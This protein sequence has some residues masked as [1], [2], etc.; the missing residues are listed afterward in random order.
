[1]KISTLS[2]GLILALFSFQSLQAQAVELDVFPLDRQLFPRDLVS[3]EAAVQVKGRVLTPGFSEMRLHVDR[4]GLAWTSQTESLVYSASGAEFDFVVNIP[5]ERANY[6]FALRLTGLGLT[7]EIARAE[8]VVCGDAILVHGQSNAVANQYDGTAN[9]NYQDDFVRSFGYQGNILGNPADS[10][11]YIAD[12]DAIFGPEVGHIGQWAMVMAQV[13]STE[14]NLPIAIINHGVGGQPISFFSNL[15]PADSSSN[16]NTLMRKSRWA[17]LKGKYRAMIWYQGESDAVFSNTADAYGNKFLN[18]WSDIST[19]LPS[20]EQLYI[21]QVRDGCGGNR[22]NINLVADD[23]RRL[24]D[25]IP[26]TYI[27]STNNLDGHDGCHY[28]FADGYRILGFRAAATVAKYL[29]SFEPFTGVV[30]PNVNS[31]R[32]TGPAR[33]QIEVQLRSADALT[34]DAG[35]EGDFNVPGGTAITGVSQV[36]DKLIIDLAGPAATSTIRYYGHENA[37][38]DIYNIR[39][40][41]LLQF[42]LPVDDFMRISTDSEVSIYPNPTQDQL[43]LNPWNLDEQRW[44]LYELSGQ[45]L[46][47]G[48]NALLDISNLAAGVYQLRIIEEGQKTSFHQIHKY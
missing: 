28:V 7:D 13:L 14:R 11:W 40:Q 34:I 2:F 9:L 24:A 31:A 42:L 19:D 46:K 30:P 36:G 35:V 25:S 48:N 3:G 8:D 39:G 5:A 16:Y 17:G 10:A 33:D 12:G 20:L 29:Y 32:F 6:D 41:G 23:Q 45:L 1:M 43:N 47:S 37:G 21:M 26:N 22:A 18:F 44:E 15:N 4:M 38:P 27:I